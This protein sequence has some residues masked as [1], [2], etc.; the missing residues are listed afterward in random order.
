MNRIFRASPEGRRGRALIVAMDHGLLDGP[1]PGL[2]DPGQTIAKVVEGGAD[3][4]LTS[5]GVARRFAG[6]LAPIGLI[7]RV[8][9]GSTSLGDSSGPGALFYGVEEALR[10]GADAVGV[11]A[12]PGAPQEMETLK[13][14][15]AVIAEAHAW[16]LP[17]MA[18]MVP[19]GF[20][21]AAEFRTRESISLSVRVAAELG[22]DFVKTPYTTGFEAVTRTC[23]VPV[24][25]L[26]GAK[27]GSERGMLADIKSAMD[28]GGAGV[29]IG[30]NIFQAEDPTT[31]AAAVAAILHDGATVD[32]ALAILG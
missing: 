31:M 26:G 21:S 28:A 12:F 7:L 1:C 20:D 23:Y 30:R 19:G 9:G 15:A 16:G 14:L 25:I 27:R 3:A 11:T 6:E 18:E 17:V 10:L 13:T 29:A 24:V 2:E 8:D 32:E 4:V 5:Y 22:A